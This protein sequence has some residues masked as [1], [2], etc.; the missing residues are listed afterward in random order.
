MGGGGSS[1]FIALVATVAISV[2]ATPAFAL[3]AEAA[4]AGEALA[5]TAAGTM[6]TSGGATV[7]ST[8][9]GQALGG[10][11]AGALG[12]AVGSGITGG[13]VGK[14]ALMGGLGGAAGGALKGAGV[15]SGIAKGI[16]EATGVSQQT[17]SALAT[18][19]QKFAT[20]TGMGLLQGRPFEEAAKQGAISGL[21]AGAF[22]S[23]LGSDAKADVGEKIA[24]GTAQG[25]V[26]GQLSSIFSPERERAGTAE[27]LPASPREAPTGQI[28]GG[29]EAL[30]ADVAGAPDIGYRG[31]I[32]FG[33]GGSEDEK[34][35]RPVWNVASLRTKQP[36]DEL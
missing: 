33:G 6:V 4:I 31:D 25:F 11:A 29:G 13:N 26:G 36:E 17:A 32:S 23:V 30:N 7:A 5:Y 27:R 3:A 21:T 14:G 2:V 20:S 12:G 15:T 24:R 10:A 9:A 8:I 18:G 1:G 35:R 34:P 19:G 16:Q 28:M 22:E